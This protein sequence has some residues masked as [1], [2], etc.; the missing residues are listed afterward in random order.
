MKALET[1]VSQN[2]PRKVICVTRDCAVRKFNYDKKYG[3]KP[4]C[5][6]AKPAKGRLSLLSSPF[7]LKS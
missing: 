1:I 6:D 3:L 7:I 2:G 5:S 4:A